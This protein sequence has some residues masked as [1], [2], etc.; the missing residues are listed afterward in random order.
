SGSNLYVADTNN[1]KIRV[2]DLKT[3]KV[4]TLDLASLSPPRLAA[5]APSF[6]NARVI[7]VPSVE[8]PAG[9]SITLEISIPLPKGFKLN[10][11]AP[12]PYLVETP[13]QSGILGPD[14]P[15]EGGRVKPP[16]TEFPIKV[17]LAKAAAAGD[18]LEL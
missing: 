9:D 10:E 6:P 18:A 17:P 12:M 15:P 1:H 3:E 14:L 13:G 16:A 11:E 4:R 7:K 8:A 5:R 2:V